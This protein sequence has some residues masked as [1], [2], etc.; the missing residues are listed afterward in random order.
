MRLAI[1]G[2][3][4]AE[5]S[6]RRE[7]LIF[8][9]FTFFPFHGVGNKS[10]RSTISNHSLCHSSANLLFL[11]VNSCWATTMAVKWFSWLLV[12]SHCIAVI[13]SEM[14][15]EAAVAMINSRQL[16]LARGPW[17]WLK[18]SGLCRRV[19]LKVKF[20]LIYFDFNFFVPFEELI[21]RKAKLVRCWVAANPE[22]LLLT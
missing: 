3:V 16:K 17:L 5:S 10:A 11:H 14:T 9:S 22:K 13:Q 18:W 6:Q 1:V 20:S 15:Q 2:R 4:A 21:N 12:A 8:V 19:G 7:K